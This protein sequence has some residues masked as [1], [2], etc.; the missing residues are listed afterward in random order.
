[1][2][3]RASSRGP[4]T[5][6]KRKGEA[7]PF[8]SDDKKKQKKKSRSKMAKLSYTKQLTADEVTNENTTT[9]S[10]NAGSPPTATN[11]IGQ[12]E[13]AENGSD[14][15]NASWSSTLK[16]PAG[17]TSSTEATD[18]A[19]T[20]TT[21][22]TTTTDT[23]TKEL[24]SQ[25]SEN[26]ESIM[27]QVTAPPPPP[28]GKTRKENETNLTEKQPDA[29]TE[30][31]DASKDQEEKEKPQEDDFPI[32]TDDSAL[33]DS[34]S[35]SLSPQPPKKSKIGEVPPV[36]GTNQARASA[37]DQT[38]PVAN[39]NGHPVNTAFASAFTSTVQGIPP[40]LPPTDHGMPSFLHGQA[41]TAQTDT[42]P[43]ARKRK[44]ANAKE[45]TY[46]EFQ[47]ESILSPV[48]PSHQ[49]LIAERKWTVDP[50]A[51]TIPREPEPEDEPSFIASDIIE[52]TNYQGETIRKQIIDFSHNC[53]ITG[54]GTG[55]QNMH[56]ISAFQNAHGGIVTRIR[57]GVHQK[58]FDISRYDPRNWWVL[59]FPVFAMVRKAASDEATRK[60][61]FEDAASKWN[62][63]PPSMRRL[64]MNTL[65]ARYYARITAS[66]DEN[67]PAPSYQP[68]EIPTVGDA[69]PDMFYRRLRD[70]PPYG[71]EMTRPSPTVLGADNA[72]D[73]I[74]SM[75]GLYRCPLCCDQPFILPSPIHSKHWWEKGDTSED[76]VTHCQVHQHAPFWFQTPNLQYLKDGMDLRFICQVLLSNAME[77]H[78]LQDTC[79][80]SRFAFY[81][82]LAEIFAHATAIALS[83]RKHLEQKMVPGS[84]NSSDWKKDVQKKLNEISKKMQRFDHF[85]WK[86]GFMGAPP[87]SDNAFYQIT[88]SFFRRG[89]FWSNPHPA[90]IDIDMDQPTMLV[91]GARSMKM[92]TAE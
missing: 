92:K 90:L 66:W 85:R 53:I 78:P 58:V 40:F 5:R 30:K 48:P 65:T 38:I 6:S 91:V 43:P 63:T 4:I 11:A 21:A 14:D 49:R 31:P 86:N 72:P 50:T 13:T 54:S 39:Q 36:G 71:C 56:P 81:T 1:M 84:G 51:P 29:L 82:A 70:L 76:L 67:E 3:T 24:N 23:T 2:S 26:Q 74:D 15:D 64:V 73:P 41:S 80:F 32:D 52:Y 55:F 62:S 77:Q 9:E 25:Q 28:Q 47:A 45:K 33:Y 10:D 27:V 83:G 88:A 59:A 16:I 89:L 42:K 8:P 69:T 75:E 79:V 22:T 17:D 57:D 7:P 18:K 20:A 12:E 44:K 87:L 19:T 34:L 35:H 46:Q 60:E 37:T 68:G 61:Q